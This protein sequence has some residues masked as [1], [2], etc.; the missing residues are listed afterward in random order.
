MTDATL[1][2]SSRLVD[3]GEENDRTLKMPAELAAER[4]AAG[5]KE[6]VETAEKATTQMAEEAGEKPTKVNRLDETRRRA[7]RRTSVR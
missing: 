1:F 4:E 6:M 7:A 3:L 2:S 5:G